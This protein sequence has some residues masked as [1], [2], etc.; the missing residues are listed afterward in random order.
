MLDLGFSRAQLLQLGELLISRLGVEIGVDHPFIWL[1]L[2]GF[3]GDDNGRRRAREEK[4]GFGDRLAL[5]ARA[6]DGDAVA[7]F[8]CSF[9]SRPSNAAR[10]RSA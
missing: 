4:V 3:I 9:A 2:V 10:P 7:Y 1:G 6:G 5:C 8:A